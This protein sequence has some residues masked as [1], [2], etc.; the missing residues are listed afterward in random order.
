[1]SLLL[2]NVEVEGSP[3]DVR[4]A[5]GRISEVAPRLIE[6][7][8]EVLDGGGG[9]LIPGLHDHHLHLYAAAAALTSITVGPSEVSDAEGLRRALSTA[10]AS[11]APGRWLR[12]VGYHESLAGDL[13]R[14]GLDRIVPHR[15]M[16]VQDRT[17]ARWTL[18]SAAIH[19]LRL[20]TRFEAGI[21]RDASGRP[22][23]RL[24]RSDVWLRDLLPAAAAPDLAALGER[25]ASVGVTGVT[26]A[27]P[28]QRPGDLTGLAA[29]VADGSLPQRVV[30]TGG[31]EL[32][33]ATPPL[34]LE[35]GPVK[36]VIDDEVYPELAVLASQIDASHRRGRPVAIHCVT[37]TSLVLA[38]AAWDAAGTL[39]GDRIEHGS[40][41]PVELITD[42]LRHGLTVVTQPTFIAERGDEYLRDV[43]PDDL[44]HLYRC[45]S[46]LDAGV[47]VAGSTDAP[48]SAPDPWQAMRAAVHRR[49]RSGAIISGEEALTP[50]RALMLFLG[51]PSEPGGPPRR[52][53]RGADADL[54]LLSRPL[55]AVFARL[56]ASDV[57]ATIRAGTVIERRT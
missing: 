31:L 16:R 18:N 7:D 56:D 30:V 55:S 25:L 3:L 15:P 17:G 52:I 40:V 20:D 45:N 36:L 53:A 6:R 5:D 9:A 24:H 32:A 29:A 47:L 54:C 12:A 37:R 4:I 38:L 44:A 57:V 23:G 26:D 49:S 39:P 19:A 48:Y 34:G 11:L 2:R 43:D 14:A 35:R 10:D 41:I 21:E 8:D 51:E 27:T 33:D 22:T 1:M 46:L 28:F 50:R 42:L 13:D